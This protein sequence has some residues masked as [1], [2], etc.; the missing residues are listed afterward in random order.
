[1]KCPFSHGSKPAPSAAASE[2]DSSLDLTRRSLLGWCA[3]IGAFGLVANLPACMG[4]AEEDDVA[5]SE[6]ASTETNFLKQ[7][8]AL[9]TTHAT[10]PAML[11]GARGALVKD[12]LNNR[13]RELFAE[14]RKHRPVL[15]TGGP[16]PTL[17]A[18]Y[19]EVTEVL[20]TN[21][22]YQV[23]P[24]QA[25]ALEALGGPF[26]LADSDLPRHDR[27][28]AAHMQACSKSDADAYR[29]IVRAEVDRLITELPKRGSIDVVR[30]MGRKLPVRILGRYFGVPS[31]PVGQFLA[32]KQ[33]GGPDFAVSED[34]MYDWIARMFRN[35]FL[36]LGGDPAVRSSGRQAAKEL[37][38]YLEK[39]IAWRKPSLAG[40]TAMPEDVLGRFIVMASR[41]PQVFPNDQRIAANIAGIIAGAVVT[42]EKVI[43]NVMDVL[44]DGAWDASVWSGAVAAAQRD[45]TAALWAYAQEALRFRPQGIAIPRV[46]TQPTTLGGIQIPA[47]QLVL[48]AHPSAMFDPNVFPKPD[49]F[50]VDARSR[51]PEKYMHFG[52]RR[53]ECLGKFMAPVE[54]TEALRGML[55]LRNLHKPAGSTLIYKDPYP[56]TFVLAYG[57]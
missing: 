15:H 17:V 33:A 9:A 47:K 50:R 54:I 13:Y 51:P 43:A 52:Y 34:I 5:G 55:R 10:N 6:A 8:D 41:Y 4:P 16:V 25:E 56:D 24:Y 14:L 49:E 48:A 35:F 32:F 42:I 31:F 20:D 45:D 11:I 39:L 26:T 44:L 27:D 1:M 53:Y 29:A 3:G 2:P 46:V 37:M 7:Y 36:N 38:A 19:P 30:D 40:A 21:D 18:L 57:P 22:V 12:W 23:I 28:K